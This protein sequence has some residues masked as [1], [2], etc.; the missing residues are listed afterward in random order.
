VEASDVSH[1]AVCAPVRVHRRLRA[2][3]DGSV[4]VL[5]RGLH[6]IYVDV[7]GWCVGLVDAQAAQVPN[8]L[9]SRARGRL[10]LRGI[11]A[12]LVGGVLHIDGTPLR[13]GRID[14]STGC[15]EPR[16]APVG[17]RVNTPMDPHAAASLVGAGT[18][19][20]PYG[21][22]VLCG[23]LAMH[24]AARVKTPEIDDAV[25]GLLHRTTLLSA[26]L[27]DCAIH[28][29]VVPEFAA[30]VAALGTPA[31][32]DCAGALSAVGGSSGAGLLRG[33][34]SALDDLRSVAEVAACPVTPRSAPAPTPTR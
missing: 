19:L 5:H 25:R 2:A 16:I 32:A 10:P 7:G 9:R 34:R 30:Y 17:G 28:G 18:G 13:V 22:D 27:L 24:R 1:L 6:A 11:E 31:E 26:T 8:G 4:P 23:W 29:E 33:A 12:H 14:V 21:D 3:P 20:T 15:V